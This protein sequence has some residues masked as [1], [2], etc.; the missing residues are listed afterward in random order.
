MSDKLKKFVSEH[1][2]EMD[3]QSPSPQVWNSLSKQFGSKPSFFKALLQKGIVKAVLVVAV[4]PATIVVYTLVKPNPETPKVVNLTK[5]NA[6]EKTQ[7]PI[8]SE[9][10][11]TDQNN[12]FKNVEST[13]AIKENKSVD[14]ISA[15]G[16][17]KNESRK[18]NAE[19]ASTAYL[20]KGSVNPLLYDAAKSSSRQHATPGAANEAKGFNFASVISNLKCNG[21]RSGKID[22]T[23]ATKGI[24]TFNWA[25]GNK[26]TEDISG[27]SA[28]TYT[29]TVSNSQGNVGIFNYSVT[30]PPALSLSVNSTQSVCGMNNGSAFV[31]V[32][33][34]GVAPYTFAWSNGNST[35]AIANL[36]GGAYRVAVTDNA[37]CSARGTV[38]VGSATGVTS[39]FTASTTN[40]NAPLKVE[41]NNSS[42]GGTTYLW[43]F[44]DGET[45]SNL[46]AAHTYTQAGTFHAAL[47]AQNT[48]GCRDSI[49]VE[50][51]V[52]AESPVVI[53]NIFTPNGDG[54]NDNLVVETKGIERI[55]MS[56]Y[57]PAGP[58]VWETSGTSAIWDGRTNTGK[59]A[60]DGTYYYF[61][62][63]YGF[64]NR[65]Y[66]HKGFI[67]LRR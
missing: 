50:I 65:T 17:T 56:I 13:E 35:A 45:E 64:D 49:S 36:S 19:K 39:G 62:K 8:S 9:Q 48:F 11:S 18:A 33:S 21:D 54:K 27:L 29:V 32:N 53:P 16:I 12:N 47:I 3:L 42:M 5:E 14:V 4:V 15:N 58:L 25:P 57:D 67:T 44:G 38:N 22:L 20:P 28:G 31:T 51:V 63:A 60:A 46:N 7:L 26:N 34:G 59:Q 24:Y 43:K 52:S 2:S 41:F 6:S 30:E 37:G 66:E 55:E 61:V 40:G 1:R 10:L 23:P